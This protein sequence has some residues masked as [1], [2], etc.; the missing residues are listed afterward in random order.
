[1]TFDSSQRL[2]ILSKPVVRGSW[3]SLLTNL[4]SYNMYAMKL[5][6]TKGVTSLAKHLNWKEQHQKLTESKRFQEGGETESW[7][8][9]WSP[10]LWPPSSSSFNWTPLDPRHKSS[11]RKRAKILTD[12]NHSRS[13]RSKLRRLWTPNVSYA[14]SESHLLFAEPSKAS[15]GC[16]GC[17]WSS[18]GIQRKENL[19]NS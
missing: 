2:S 4:M 19:R 1:M 18:A 17:L 8:L 12:I 3:F 14:S 13:T 9:H 5:L 15:R 10:D 11:R 7:D 16:K 6:I